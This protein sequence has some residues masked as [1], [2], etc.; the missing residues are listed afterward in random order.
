MHIGTIIQNQREIPKGRAWR[1]RYRLE[2]PP[3]CSTAGTERWVQS[4]CR[5][6]ILELA[7]T[8]AFFDHCAVSYQ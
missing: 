7:R 3:D 6:S 4:L 8:P 2:N 1:R 5:R